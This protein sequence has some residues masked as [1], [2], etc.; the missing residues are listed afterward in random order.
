MCSRPQQR[1]SHISLPRLMRR[2]SVISTFMNAPRAC[3]RV[4]AREQ[5]VTGGA[6]VEAPARLDAAGEEVLFQDC[7]SA[8]RAAGLL[9]LEPIQRHVLPVLLEEHTAGS[10][11]NGWLPHPG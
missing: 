4:H 2:Y 5:H 8:C 10:A 1:H 6:D 9:V 7:R 3:S 11:G